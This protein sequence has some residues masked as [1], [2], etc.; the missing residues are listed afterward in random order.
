MSFFKIHQ[1][2]MSIAV[3]R[4]LQVATVL[5]L[6]LGIGFGSSPA[7]A[8]IELKPG[9]RVGVTAAGLGGMKKSL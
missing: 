2:K 4:T 3:R 9:V 5:L 8:Q 6:G 1:V 7:Q